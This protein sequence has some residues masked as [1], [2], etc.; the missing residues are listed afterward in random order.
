MANVRLQN[1]LKNVVKEIA[2]KFNCS[3]S[4]AF[5]RLI[6]EEVFNMDEFEIDEVI[7]DG[8]LDKGVDAIFEQENEEGEN[9]LYV[10][11][12][13]YYE[14]NYNKTID[15]NSVHLII[16]AVSNYILGDY[17]LGNLN[18]K[19]RKR[20]EVYRD[21][22]YAK[23]EID[24]INMVLVTNGQRPGNNIISELDRFKEDNPQIVYEIYTEDD[25]SSILLPE[26]ARVV[27]KIELKV[28]KEIGSGDRTFLNMPDLDIMSGKVV[29]VDVYE[30]AKV[31]ENKVNKQIAESLR[32][33]GQIK[34]FIYLNNGITFL[35]DD[36][37]VKLGNETIVLKHPSIINGCQTG[38]TI[39]EV[40]K[41]GKI[42]PNCG[43]ILAKIIKSKDDKV[44]ENIILAS[45]T[46]IPVRNRDLIS[47]DKIQKELERQFLT[48]GYYYERKKG[49]HRDKPKDKVIDLE[50]AA[51][52]YL[53][54][55]LSRPAEAKNKKSEIYKSYYKQIFHK[56]ISAEQLLISFK[57]FVAV[58][59]RIRELRKSAEPKTKSILGNSVLHLLPLYREWI[60]RPANMDLPL[61]EKDISRMEFKQGDID[62]VVK[63]MLRVLKNIA[64]KED[65]NAQYFFKSANSLSQILE[66]KELKAKY[67]IVLSRDNRRRY[68]DLRYYKPQE[69]SIDGDNFE[70]VKHW[71]DLFA[72]L[73]NRYFDKFDSK[74][75]KLDF[76]DVKS[77]ELLLEK[78]SD[79]EKKFRKK[80]DNGL[81]LLT[82]FSSIKIC[83]YCYAIAERLDFNLIIKLRPTKCRIHRKYK[84]KRRKR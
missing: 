22:I 38:N 54:L 17:P 45:N 50:K 55:Y 71:N 61:I 23:N 82:N 25:F 44:K 41:E 30:L 37:E 62:K 26:T 27:R 81:W 39:L 42:K 7:T 66:S 52:A 63:R 49:M 36:Y 48:L 74:G 8:A 11:Q 84:K 12:A 34:R 58:S 10:L 16:N 35:C 2:N 9:I 3:I 68:K 6:L 33:P 79:E 72:S 78:P 73:M 46:Q 70:K 5:I 59:S 65:F 19:L 31:I 43:F 20:V 28:V 4:I 83:E 56:D 24:G 53:A 60:L 14:K 51:Q 57:L 40:Y 80:L 29:R 32:D 77:R 69:Y 15:E 75:V 64:K 1:T 67:E 18:S 13:K 76:V 47:E 21:R